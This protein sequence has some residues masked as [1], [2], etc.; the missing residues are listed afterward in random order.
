M[1]RQ[2]GERFD[3]ESR[4]RSEFKVPCEIGI[5]QYLTAPP[6]PGVSAQQQL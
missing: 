2:R 5:V 1:S 4:K 6:L 3:E